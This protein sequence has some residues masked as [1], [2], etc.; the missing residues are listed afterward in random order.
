MKKF[1]KWEFSV[2]FNLCEYVLCGPACVLFASGKLGLVCLCFMSIWRMA[3][4]SVGRC[5]RA[6]VEEAVAR[7]VH[8]SHEL[9]SS[10]CLLEQLGYTVYSE[11]WK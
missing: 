2:I 11:A 10:F 3:H 7:S 8:G 1:S 5:L 6:E 9:L 4:V